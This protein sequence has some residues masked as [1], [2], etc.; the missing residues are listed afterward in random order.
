MT[1]EGRV[2][3]H[4]DV[5]SAFLSWEACYRKEHLGEEPDLRDLPSAVVGDKEARHGIILAKSVPA[6]K[7]GVK[8]GEPI[9]QARR[10]CPGL[11]LVPANYGLYVAA[12]RRFIALLQDYAPVVEQY[13]I[14]EAYADV[15][16][17]RRL[18]GPPVAAAYALKERI[19]RQ[20]GFTVN[21]GVSCNK[22]LAKMA[23]ELEKPD[24]VHTLFP[25]EIA[26]KMWPLPVGELFFVGPASKARLEQIGITTIG[27][28][29]RMDKGRIKALL[30]RHGELIW[31]YANGRGPEELTAETPLNKGYGNA[32]TLAADITG[33]EQ[34]RK[35]LLSLCETVGARLRA[36]GQRGRCVTVHLRTAD[37]Y[38]WSHQVRLEQASDA[39]LEL[40][41]AA[42]R[43]LEQMWRGGV[44]LRQVG[45]AVSQ[46]SRDNCRQLTLFGDRYDKLSRLDQAVDGIRRRYGE[47]A[48][49][50]ACFLQEDGVDHMAGGLDRERRTGITRPLEEEPEYPDEEP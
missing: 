21:I 22:L 5:N 39:T 42:C 17:C 34:G 26:A 3:Y 38:D 14:D 16:G 28:L 9:W 4:V 15:T 48:V 46:V 25:E 40:W 49:R 31:N 20:L 47:E 1:E 29:A 41:Q 44:P 24:K 12:S 18:Y 23:G 36:D 30:G 32:T 35:V 50:R 11:V 8:T 33:L 7:C 19:H 13:S 6:K 45:V 43:A 37:F 10:K 2:I 27:Q